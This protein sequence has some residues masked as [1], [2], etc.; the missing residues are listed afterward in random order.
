ME[1]KKVLLVEDDQFI[2]NLYERMLSKGGYRVKIA[3][4]GNEAL[5]IAKKESF[6]LLLLD[7]MMPEKDGFQ[8]LQELKEDNKTR[9]LNVIVLSNLDDDP[10]LTKALSLGAKAYIIKS[11]ASPAKVLEEIKSVIG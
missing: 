7:I 1:E 10:L 8:V 5:E 2:R 3:T 6:D 9:D 11:S 4:N